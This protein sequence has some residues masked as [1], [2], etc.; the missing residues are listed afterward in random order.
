MK[1]LS[2]IQTP[3]TPE[4]P[5]GQASNFLRPTTLHRYD[6]GMLQRV[7]DMVAV[8]EPLR[9][10]APGLPAFDM[11]R[12]P[13]DDENLVAG[14]LLC[15][16]AIRDRE[17]ILDITLSERQDCAIVSFA[18]PGTRP[19]RPSPR[20]EHGPVDVH[21]FFDLKHAF[22]RRQKLFRNTGASHA[23]ALFSLRGEL[24]AFGEDVGRHN[25]FDKAVGNAMHSGQ[26]HKAS[27]AM[28]SS[29]LAL[30]LVNKAESVG[31]PILCGFSVATSSAV[32]RAA[33]L[34]ITLV[35]RIRQDTMNIYT[36]AWPLD[37]I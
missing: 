21:R 35:G 22:E 33:S 4:I 23:A 20:P 17:D 24:V 19:V 11:A 10:H 12:T 3:G 27:I 1:R 9:V 26:L 13:G 31:I 18:P 30:E 32:Q 15:M 2:G 5:V 16:G 14:H 8:E 36:C 25:A 29:R 37:E 28:L 34:G 6:C 7:P